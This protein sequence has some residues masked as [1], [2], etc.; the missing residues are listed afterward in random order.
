MVLKVG[1]NQYIMIFLWILLRCKTCGGITTVD[2]DATRMGDA[3][4]VVRYGRASQLGTV[5][6]VD[7]GSF[8]IVFCLIY[9][10]F[11]RI[12]I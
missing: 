12:I 4:T 5:F 9:I 10:R 8:L 3:V 2:F 7:K 11:F 6:T 1:L